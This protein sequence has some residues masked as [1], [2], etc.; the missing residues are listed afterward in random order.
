MKILQNL[1]TTLLLV[2]ITGVSINTE[3]LQ[4]QKNTIVVTEDTPDSVLL[5]GIDFDKMAKAKQP[6]SALT[7]EIEGVPHDIEVKTEGEKTML[8]VPPVSTETADVILQT[9]QTAMQKDNVEIE[10]KPQQK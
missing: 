9:Y 2:L 3:A 1:M 5:K 10:F 4:Q 7:L 8:V 6:A